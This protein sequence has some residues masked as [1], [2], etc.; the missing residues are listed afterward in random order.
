MIGLY[1]TWS[2]TFITARTIG[3]IKSLFLNKYTHW[4]QEGEGAWRTEE[5][6]NPWTKTYSLRE[7]KY[8]FS[9]YDISKLSFRKTSFSW[10]NAIPKLGKHI[11]STKIGNLLANKFHPWL[12]S[13]WIITFEKNLPKNN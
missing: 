13:M 7:L 6:L 9:K 3:T 12:G 8:L 4:Y 2:P 5:N 1:N 11:A 10:G